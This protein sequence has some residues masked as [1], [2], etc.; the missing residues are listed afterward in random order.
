MTSLPKNYRLVRAG[1]TAFRSHIG[2]LLPAVPQYRIVP[3]EEADPALTAVLQDD[4]ALVMAGTIHTDKKAAEE[5]FA[6]LKAGR[7]CDTH[8]EH[9]TPLYIKE[10]M[11][12]INPQTHLSSGEEKAC[13]PLISDLVEEFARQTREAEAVTCERA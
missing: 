4:E 13:E 9:G 1:T 6:A 2:E 3:A 12:N 8:K 10:N 7:E 5:R 11:S